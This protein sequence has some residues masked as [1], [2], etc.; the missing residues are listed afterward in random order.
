MDALQ[1]GEAFPGLVSDDT[2]VFKAATSRGLG[3]FSFQVLLP[4]SRF[5]AFQRRLQD[6]YA[7]ANSTMV[8][9]METETATARPG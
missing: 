8:F 5:A 4:D 7:A 9:P 1:A 3:V 6:E 2:A